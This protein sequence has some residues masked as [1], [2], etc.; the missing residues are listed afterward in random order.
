MENE[1]FAAASVWPAIFQ[2]SFEF[3]KRKE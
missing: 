1:E 3:F 2:D